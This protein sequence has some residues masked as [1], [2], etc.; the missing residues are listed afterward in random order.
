MRVT[1]FWLKI[2]ERGGAD[3]LRLAISLSYLSQLILNYLFFQCFPALEAQP[4]LLDEEETYEPPEDP[5]SGNSVS[6]QPLQRA[7]FKGPSWH[8]QRSPWKSWE[9]A[10]YSNSRGTAQLMVSWRLTR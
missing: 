7:D 3:V 4:F 5:D 10:H 8:T 2:G 1:Y 9:C 6:P